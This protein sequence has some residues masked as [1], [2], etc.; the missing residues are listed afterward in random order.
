MQETTKVMLKRT[1]LHLLFYLLPPVFLSA[2]FQA[3]AQVFRQADS[4]IPGAE[5]MEEYLPLLKGKKTGILTNHTGRIGNTHLVDTLL[6]RGVDVQAVFAPEHGFRGD[7]D[8]GETVRGYRDPRTGISVVSIYGAHKKP[9]Q[10]EIRKLDVVLFDIQDVGLRFYTYLSSMHYMMEA[11][12]EAG[13]P[14]IV[15]DRPNPNGMYVDGPVLDMTL[16]SFVGMHPIPVVHG[17]TLGE[18]ARMIHGEGW[19]EGALRCDLHVIPCVN[20]TRRTRYVLPERP[21]PNLPNMRSIYLYPSLCPFEGSV[22]SLGRGTDFPFQVYGHPKLPDNGFSF[23]PQAGPGALNPPWKGQR[24]Y[25]RDLRTDPSDEAV[26]SNGL[27][28]SYLISAYRMLG[29]GEQ[30]F[31]PMFDKLLGVRYVRQMIVAG[32][33]AGSIKARWRGDVERFKE[34]RRAYLLYGKE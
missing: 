10:E 32:E 34:S 18:L 12:A 27:D 11:C 14:M 17:M 2:V 19:L 9:K 8:A 5:R 6:A 13:V 33:S 16:R 31:N 22:V 21:S 30:F 28:L 24:C 20:Y 7:A 4:V 15:L 3:D 1:L 23:M 25:G 29:M 26:I